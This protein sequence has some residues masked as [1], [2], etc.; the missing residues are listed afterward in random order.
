VVEP[1]DADPEVD[2]ALSLQV[3]YAVEPAAEPPAQP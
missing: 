2:V 1:F 3:L